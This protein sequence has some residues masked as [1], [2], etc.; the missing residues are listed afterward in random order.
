MWYEVNLTLRELLKV[1]IHSVCVC[2]CV[3]IHLHIGDVFDIFV[4]TVCWFHIRE[5]NKL[6]LISYK[7]KAMATHSSVL[8]WRIPW[9]EKPGRLQSMGSHRVG[10]NWSDLAAAAATISYNPLQ[11][12][13]R[14]S[15]HQNGFG[16]R[17]LI[18]GGLWMKSSQGCAMAVSKRVLKMM[19]LLWVCSS[20]KPFKYLNIQC[21]CGVIFLLLFSLSG[22]L[23]FKT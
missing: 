15:F 19:W 1:K 5:F 20:K 12:N 10:H 18:V 4:Y 7:E 21:G 13:I 16:K 11:C 14:I 23:C 9:T 2:V 22:P 8:A 6:G 17:Y 3:C